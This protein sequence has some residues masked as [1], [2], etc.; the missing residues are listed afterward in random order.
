MRSF[1]KGLVGLVILV[2]LV[3]LGLWLYANMR[4]KQ[5]V[6]AEINH[7]NA[8]GTAHI[9]YH[10]ITT[11]HSPILASVTVSQPRWTSQPDP[12]VPAVTASAVSLGAHVSLLHPL[13]L[14]MDMPLTI[15]ISSS[16]ASGALTFEAADITETLSPSIWL[17]NSTNPVSSGNAHFEGVNL[18]ASNGSLEV[19]KI[20]ALTLHESLNAKAGPSQTALD[21][22]E[23]MHHFS[24]S[25]ILT[26][27]LNLPFDG[28][29]EH[30]S[31]SGQLSGPLD[32]RSIAE[33][34]ANFQDQ[35]QRDKFMLKT[36]HQ[37]AMAGGSG[38][39]SLSLKLGPSRFKA[40]GK[41]AFDKAGQPS[42]KMD[43]TA[44][45]LDQFTNALTG[46][47]PGLQGWVSQIEA[48]LS[49]YLSTTSDGGQVLTM[50]TVYG[51][52]GI[53]VNGQKT[54]SPP[55]LDWNML[56]NPPHS[57]APNNASGAASP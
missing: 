52:N 38:H 13:T 40:D 5:L 19:A 3:W 33:Q 44:D 31:L 50:H 35:D 51:K 48:R 46:S 32:W 26:R 22:Q 34:E 11:S 24:L 41:I 49:P 55:S 21:L 7:V 6:T 56:L 10:N 12:S 23:D 15:T 53:V 27:L 47:Y 39:G 2:A 4:L 18:L 9:S 42:G 36:L 30:I 54:S 29:I 16:E 20:G 8:S 45:H 1:I 17:G 28:K 14:H 43:L 25:P 57:P 37:W